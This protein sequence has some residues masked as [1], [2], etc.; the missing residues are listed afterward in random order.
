[1]LVWLEHSFRSFSE[2][3]HLSVAC[4]FVF[5]I[6]RSKAIIFDG[7]VVFAKLHFVACQRIALKDFVWSSA[8]LVSLG[9]VILEVT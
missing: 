6:V 1:M 2:T 5:L 3:T 8:T 7:L 4:E 9:Y